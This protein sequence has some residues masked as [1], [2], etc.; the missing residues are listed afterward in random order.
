VKN[1]LGETV[2]GGFAPI[3]IDLTVEK[4]DTIATAEA[5]IIEIKRIMRMMWGTESVWDHAEGHMAFM[6]RRENVFLKRIE[7]L[8][9]DIKLLQ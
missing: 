8:E 2:R 6:K 1:K 9:Q 3:H 5:K 7:E 4:K